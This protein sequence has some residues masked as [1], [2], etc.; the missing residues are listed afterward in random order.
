MAKQGKK[1]YCGIA[2]ID[3]IKQDIYTT[4][5]HFMLYNA[6]GVFKRYISKA[7]LRKAGIYCFTPLKQLYGPHG[8]IGVKYDPD[9]I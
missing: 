4:G 6:F 5:T 2:T 3:G 8:Y 1:E 7:A 9:H